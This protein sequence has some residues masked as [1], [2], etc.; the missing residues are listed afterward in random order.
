MSSE[1]YLKQ[2]YARILIPDPG[3]GFSA[4]ILEFPGCFSQG[5]TAE[6]AFS[7][8]ENAAMA[9]IESAMRQGQEIPSP[10]AHHG[11]TGKIALRLPKSIHRKAAQFAE[12]DG[13][14]LN[15]FL[16]SAIAARLGAEDLHARLIER[17]EEREGSVRAW[18]GSF[19]LPVLTQSGFAEVNL[20]H[21]ASPGFI[22]LT[23]SKAVVPSI[24]NIDWTMRPAH[25]EEKHAAD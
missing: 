15:Q 20:F 13:T 17:L 6:E 25:K 5:K 1:E 4:E 21:P 3:G 7:N 19:Q 23:C 14:S 11:Y 12:R 10:S 22:D 8:L 16:V 18:T 9:W 24:E 2:P